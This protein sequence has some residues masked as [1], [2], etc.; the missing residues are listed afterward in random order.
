MGLLDDE[1]R[2]LSGL[3]GRPTTPMSET[4]RAALA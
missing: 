1:S 2:A 3:I 4:V